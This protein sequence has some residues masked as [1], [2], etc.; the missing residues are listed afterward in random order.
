MNSQTETMPVEAAATTWKSSL[1]NISYLTAVGIATV[2][3]LSA[4]GWAALE[5]AKRLID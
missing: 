5:I 1:F 3:W 4:L 2:G